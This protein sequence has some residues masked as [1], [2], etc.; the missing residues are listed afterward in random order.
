VRNFIVILVALIISG[1]ANGTKTVLVDKKIIEPKVI[2]LD[3][4]RTPWVIEIENRLRQKGFKVLR[5]ASTRNVKEQ[6]SE[7]NTEEFRLASTRYI[8][9][10]QGSA[11]LDVMHHC[12]AGGYQFDYIN[13]DLIDTKTNE[14]ILNI[15]G[16]GYSE[17]CPPL[18]GT[19]FKD[20][21]SGVEGAWQ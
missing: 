3:A 13:T 21:V 7:K 5:S 17:N 12:F 18:S 4:P 19:I 2:A 14:T 8:L 20:I 9:S 10:I 16:S 11:P 15:S 1:C 6:V